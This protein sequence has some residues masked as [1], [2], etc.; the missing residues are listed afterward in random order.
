MK[1]TRRYLEAIA[2]ALSE[3]D[4]TITFE[5]SEQWRTDIKTRTI[6]YNPLDLINHDIDLVKGLLLHEY[7]HVKYTT[8][9][10][11]TKLEKEHRSIHIAY[12][13][14]EDMRIENKVSRDFGDFAIMP[15]DIVNS[16]GILRK[17]ENIDRVKNAPKLDQ[18]LAGL[19]LFI[20][21]EGSERIINY[22]IGNT[23]LENIQSSFLNA[24]DKGVQS[25]LKKFMNS[26]SMN[27][28]CTRAKRCYDTA[29]IKEFTEK[30][31][32]P[33]IKDYLDEADSEMDFKMMVQ[34]KKPGI[35]SAPP[36]LMPITHPIPTD[37]E[38]EALFNPY[39]STLARKLT[40]ILQEKQ[41]TKYSDGKK[42]GKLLSKNTY[43]VLSDEKRI[44][45]RKTNPDKPKYVVTLILD[46]SGSMHGGNKVRGAYM[47]AYLLIKTCKK[48]GFDVNLIGMSDEAWTIDELSEYRLI[49]GGGNEEIK[50]LDYAMKLINRYD[51]NLLF[52]MTDGLACSNHAAIRRR[53]TK[54]EIKYNTDTIAIGIELPQDDINIMKRVYPR[55]IA[56]D[57]AELLPRAMIN[58]M[59]SLIKR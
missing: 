44:F 6:E 19:Q 1:A 36:D 37:N 42:Q 56:V 43:K 33:Y 16:Y 32:L 23:E 12:N 21:P 45:S 20:I 40:D 15:F 8:E 34:L 59:Q 18:F 29:S 26:I 39:I 3:E 58:L 54:L 17:G 11:K 53:L 30:Q 48:M 25:N 24:M 49:T 41:A 14:F 2:T 51:D 55:S 46:N 31:L 4:K 10:T 22:L 47:G 9:T 5:E 35:G 13:V 7:G 27:L 50:A 57:K 52:L 28:L 38:L